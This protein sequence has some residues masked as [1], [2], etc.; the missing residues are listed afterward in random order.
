MSKKETEEDL[1]LYAMV[2]RAKSIFSSYGITPGEVLD[3]IKV[4]ELQKLNK[5]L[6]DMDTSLGKIYEEMYRG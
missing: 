5:I 2:K 6:D 1:K 4:I 3:A